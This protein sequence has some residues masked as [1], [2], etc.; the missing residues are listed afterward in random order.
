MSPSEESPEK[1]PSSFAADYGRRIRWFGIWFLVGIAPFLGKVKVPGFSAL[2]ELY[3]A[4]LQ[5]WLI[6]LSGIFMGMMA[7]VV[8]F[9]A[10]RHAE[11]AV[12]VRW[13]V[14]NTAVFLF[15]LLLLVSVYIFTVVQMERS[16][17]RGP[18]AVPEVVNIAVI[19]GSRTVPSQYAGS[20]CKCPLGEPAERCLAD[21][22]LKPEN[23]ALCFGSNRIAFSTLALVLLYL[24]VTGS[25]VAAVGLLLMRQ[26][27]AS[28]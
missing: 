8:E 4:S 27:S 26:R 24:A 13:F 11:E 18:N 2:I 16:I 1:P 21:S 12:L 28:Q 23:V 14:R 22:S 7:V 20:D 25:F 9:V 17:I 19:T 3:P 10:S 5:G 15:A 6:P